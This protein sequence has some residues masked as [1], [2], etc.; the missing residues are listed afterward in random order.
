MKRPG[1]Y[2][3]KL[4]ASYIVQNGWREYEDQQGRPVRVPVW[5]T[6]PDRMS[7]DCIWSR[8]TKAKDCKGC[9]HQ[10]K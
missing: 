10:A 6:V 2:N 4:K 3:R 9:I 5:V 8:E 7:R 1:C